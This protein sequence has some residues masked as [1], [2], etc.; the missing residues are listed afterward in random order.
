M[1]FDGIETDVIRPRRGSVIEMAATR[2]NGL[3]VTGTAN[4][5]QSDIDMNG[6]RIHNLADPLAN[7][8]AATKIYVDTAVGSGSA[9]PLTTVGDLLVRD[10]TGN[11]RLPIGATNAVLTVNPLAAP[12]VSWEQPETTLIQT[13]GDILSTNGSQRTVLSSNNVDGNVLTVDSTA[14][15]G[16]SWKDAS[17]VT[18]SFVSSSVAL[19]HNVTMATALPLPAETVWTAP[20][21]CT[22][23]GAYLYIIDNVLLP[24]LEGQSGISILL[25][26]ES[27]QTLNGIYSLSVGPFP[28]D[29]TMTRRSDYNTSE[30][31]HQ[32]DMVFVEQGSANVYKT[33]KMTSTFTTL[34]TD[35]IVWTETPTL[36]LTTKGDILIRD[37]NGIS[38]LPVP[39]W[40]QNGYV[41]KFDYTDPRGLSWV[42][43]S[44][45]T[46]TLGGCAPHFGYAINESVVS[47]VMMN[48]GT[49]VWCRCE[50][51]A[52]PFTVNG[53]Y[54]HTLPSSTL[55]PPAYRPLNDPFI[56]YVPMSINGVIQ[57]M[58]MRIKTDGNIDILSGTGGST[59]SVI[60]QDVVFYKCMV[61][62]YIG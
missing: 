24:P 45:M 13:K 30:L 29:I 21:T 39:A 6:H 11:N 53:T 52:S 37:E 15:T 59:Y 23:G 54:I 41:L 4:A 55:I 42:A 61:S 2:I 34:Y 18:T 46:Y 25:K 20:G 27:D 51:F 12:L 50:G 7:G 62:W 58:I 40:T 32:G 10:S 44:N 26:N 9:V 17:S 1:S 33:F 60:G 22:I 28:Y 8:D 19:K 3:T 43:P 49:M 36:P 31:I 38:K 57:N 35:P 16:L 56:V 47:F 5:F 48:I 14:A